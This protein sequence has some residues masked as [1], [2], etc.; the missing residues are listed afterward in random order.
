MAAAREVFTE[1]GF[2]AT[3]VRDI[4]RRTNLASGTFYNYFDSK[5]DVFKA[6]NDEIGDHLRGALRQ[7]RAEAETVEEFLQRS[8]ETYFG[9]Y[10]E[11]PEAYYLMRAN[12]DIDAFASR[13]TGEQEQAGLNEMR[14]DIEKAVDSGSVPEI[15]VGYLTACLGGV[16][17]SMLDELMQREPIDVAHATRFAV[18]LFMAGVTGLRDA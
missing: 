2:G 11:N 17:F 18:R 13:I 6:L 12:P 14:A 3:T 15:D 9:Y 8:F 4:I 1:L 7:V 16:A 10:L 5:E